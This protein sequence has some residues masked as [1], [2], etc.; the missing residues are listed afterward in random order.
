MA[1]GIYDD[2]GKDV[3]ESGMAGELVCTRPHPSIPVCFWGDDARGT[4]FLKAYYDT[5]PGVWR[6]GDFIAMNPSTRGYIIFGRRFASSVP[7]IFPRSPCMLM[8]APVTYS[9]GV[10]NPSGVRFGTGEIYSVLER[11]EFATRVDD[12]ICVGQR[13]PQDKDERVLLFI[14]MRAG[15]KLDEPFEQAIRAAIRAALSA[16]HVPA[17]IFEVDD[18]P[19]SGISRFCARREEASGSLTRAGAGAVHG[20]RQEDRDR[21]QEDRLG[22]ARRAEC[23]GRQPGCPAGLLQV[24]GDRAVCFTAVERG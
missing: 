9:D 20:Q 8:R 18:I 3:S 23:Y 24:P 7:Y 4:L 6:H 11:P 15:H 12:S 21:S 1:V 16:R 13:R 14:K 22:R 19:V 10:L 5:Y 2:A 17:H